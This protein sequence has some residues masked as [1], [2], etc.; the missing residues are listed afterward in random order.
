MVAK[1]RLQL[2]AEIEDFFGKPVYAIV[3]NPSFEEGISEGDERYFSFFIEKIL[4]P[5]KV[6]DCIIIMSGL[7][8]NL[9]TSLLCSQILRNNL[10]NY[11]VFIPTVAGS[12]L[13]YFI[14][15]SNLLLVGNKS[16]LTQIDPVFYNNGEEYRCINC[17]NHLD[18][19]IK[20]FATENFNSVFEIL[21]DII[22]SDKN[23]F[24]IEVVKRSRKKLDYL[25]LVINHWMKKDGSHFDKIDLKE[26]IKLKVKFKKITPLIVEG[27]INL[28][29]LCREELYEE[30]QRF[31]IQTNLKD[32]DYLG[33]FFFS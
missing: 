4:K 24:D 32:E 14:L 29:N 26:L 30:N 7:G 15:N 12:S 9:K 25:N 27:A 18:P 1:N 16:I 31:V 8:G 3:Y 28:I 21:R 5:H 22:T 33:G 11:S 17:L 10:E 19:K 6:K 13:C 20:R 23:V 2:I